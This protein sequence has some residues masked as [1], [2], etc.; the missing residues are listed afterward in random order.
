MADG[1][2]SDLHL[3]SSC[4]SV[5]SFI[6]L[7][8][9]H[10]EMEIKDNGIPYGVELDLYLRFIML[11]RLFLYLPWGHDEIKDFGIPQWCGCRSSPKL[12]M[13]A[14]SIYLDL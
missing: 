2:E 6:C 14:S 9:Q 8:P 13:A 5:Y 4:L 7:D 11:V 10:D 1:V 3:D 12:A